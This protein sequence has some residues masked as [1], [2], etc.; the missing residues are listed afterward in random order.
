MNLADTGSTGRTTHARIGVERWGLV[1]GGDAAR[2]FTLRNAHDMR[3]AISDLGATLVS[4]HAPDRSG[5]IADVLLGHDTPA[6]YLAAS[7]FMGGTIGRWANRI[8]GARFA[9]D[10]V[11]Y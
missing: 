7:A 11:S 3:V 9:L 10:G 2:L 5:R 4:W 1:P 8:A 6:D